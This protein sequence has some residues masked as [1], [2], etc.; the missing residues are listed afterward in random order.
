MEEGKTRLPLLEEVGRGIL[1]EMT[2]EQTLKYKQE[3]SKWKRRGK[4]E[5]MVCAKAW[6]H[7]ERRMASWMALTSSVDWGL[8]DRVNSG[9]EGREM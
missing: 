5:G 9:P 8:G 3:I 4:A 2:F 6:W 7:G 1:E